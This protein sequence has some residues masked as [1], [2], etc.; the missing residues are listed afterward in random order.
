M[1]IQNISVEVKEVPTKNKR[2][3]RSVIFSLGVLSPLSP[4]FPFKVKISNHHC[5][6]G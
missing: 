4:S 1:F 3:G 5:T 6:V 2:K